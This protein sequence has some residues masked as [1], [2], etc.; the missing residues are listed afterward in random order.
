[1]NAI[2]PSPKHGTHA[3]TCRDRYWQSLI[4][5]SYPAL[6][7]CMT[8]ILP[9]MQPP[10]RYPKASHG[11]HSSKNQCFALEQRRSADIWF[12]LNSVPVALILTWLDWNH[13][14]GVDERSW[15][16]ATP[17]WRIR[18]KSFFGRYRFCGTRGVEPV[19]TTCG[20]TSSLQS[21]NSS[22]RY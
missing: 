10:A 4:S 21:H 9:S 6:L 7:P 12:E 22:I 11:H 19:R 1:M 20:I 3:D 5:T 13:V 15:H 14:W 2:L 8:Q 18:S 17:W 16:I